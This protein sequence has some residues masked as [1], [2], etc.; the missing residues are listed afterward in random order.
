MPKKKKDQ[1]DQEEGN[2]VVLLGHLFQLVQVPEAFQVF[3]F[4]SFIVPPVLGIL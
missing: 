4:F 1:D 3:H 2:V